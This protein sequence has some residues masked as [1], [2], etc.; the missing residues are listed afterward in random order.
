MAVLIELIELIRALGQTG[1]EWGLFLL[2][3]VVLVDK[4]HKP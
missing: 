3:L 2:C 4:L 1:L